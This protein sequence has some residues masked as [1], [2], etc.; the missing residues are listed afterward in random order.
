M[1]NQLDLELETILDREG[2]LIRVL[3]SLA[4]IASEKA[5]HVQ[6][7]WQDRKLAVLWEGASTKLASLASKIVE[8]F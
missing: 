3:E 5:D 7:N 8:P 2:S 4:R 6:T 1:D